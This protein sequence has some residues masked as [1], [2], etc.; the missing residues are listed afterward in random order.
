[1]PHPSELGI[2]ARRDMPTTGKEVPLLSQRLRTQ[3]QLRA[4]NTDGIRTSG[5]DSVLGEIR[6]IPKPR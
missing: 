4:L 6:E 3:S 2:S 5:L 1:M